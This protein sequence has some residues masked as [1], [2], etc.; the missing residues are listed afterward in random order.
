VSLTLLASVK[1]AKSLLAYSRHFLQPDKKSRTTYGD[2][3]EACQAGHIPKEHA[4]LRV[5][6]GEVLNTSPPA[7]K[8]L[9]V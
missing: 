3:F 9:D 2:S 4:H 7:Y 5:V 6:V 8:Q 1:S